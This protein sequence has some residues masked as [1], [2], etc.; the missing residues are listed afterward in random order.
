MDNETRCIIRGWF[1]PSTFACIMIALGL[2]GGATIE[3][4]IQELGLAKTIAI[5]VGLAVILSA[6]II[7]ILL[8][9]FS[10][11]RFFCWMS[12]D[13]NISPTQWVW[14]MRILGTGAFAIGWIVH[15]YKFAF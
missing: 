12:K 6:I 14:V 1:D 4:S 2:V 10:R 5:V 3:Y 13:F 7:D 11:T 8:R 9:K 15:H